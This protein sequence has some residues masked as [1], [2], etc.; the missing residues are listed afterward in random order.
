MI[1]DGTSPTPISYFIL[2]STNT[3]MHAFYT[4][5]LSLGLVLMLP[6]YLARFG[7]YGPTIGER[8]GFIDS[9]RGPTIWLHA[10]SVGEVK[11]V[12]RLIEGLRIRRPEC[13][14]VVSTT[15]PTGRG[16]AE[17][18]KDIDRIVYFPLDLPGAV[19]RSLD[20]V[21]P[22]LVIVAETEIWPNFLR[23]C[24]RRGIPV[25]MVN[26]RISDKSYPRYLFVRRWLRA[27]LD[28][29]RVL[30]MQSEMDAERI[31]AMGAKPEKVVV[32]G[33]MKYD[34][35]ASTPTLDPDLANAL[36][37]L[38]PLWV[39]ASTAA[40]E[41]VLVLEAYRRLRRSNPDLKLLIA[42]RLTQRFDEVARSL[43]GD[44]FRYIRR[45][46]NSFVETDILLLDSIGELTAVFEYATV[47]FMGGTLVPRGGHNVLEPAR[48]RK[49][50]VF[51]PHME[52][53]REMA[54]AFLDAGAAVRVGNVVELVREIQRLLDSPSQ[55]AELGGCGWRLLEK[56]Q[57]ATANALQSIEDAL[58]SSV[59][60]G[61]PG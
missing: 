10:V 16:L 45:S 61:R 5:A 57:G 17:K 56:N 20:R 36:R 40:G 46:A 3:L 35:P 47:V 9:E 24:K 18:R 49:A 13:R 60:G 39:A 6:Y 44:E 34:L 23:Q 38:Q 42:P 8:L 30:G 37:S 27:V 29:Y 41:E 50:V 14:L 53:F 32:F 54:R 1:T 2:W 52:N 22:E 43:D 15:T 7:K 51:G 55:A 4:I 59:N 31:R 21:R 33:N 19:K 25:V 26:G 11:A 58:E 12:E 28:D 48:F